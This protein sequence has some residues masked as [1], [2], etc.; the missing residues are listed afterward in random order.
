L[1]G[2][3]GF[4]EVWA[5]DTT[6]GRRVALKFLPCSNGRSTREE[7][8][9]L[10]VVRDLHHPNL[11]RIEQIWCT[12]G[13]IVVAME[14][15]DGSLRDLL[16]VCRRDMG[17]PVM[18]DLVCQ[19]LKQA[20]TALDF[21]NARQHLVHG[22]LSAIHHCDIKPSNILLVG[23]TVKLAD[24][25][26]AALKYSAGRRPFAAGTP[27]YAAPEI[28]EGRTS[29]RTDQFALAV[30]YCELRSGRL[31]YPH[32]PPGF[33]RDYIPPPPDLSML[34]PQESPIIARALSPIPTDRWPTCVEMIDRLARVVG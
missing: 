26:L 25:G 21:L 15:A 34:T 27:A 20:A 22:Q 14:L 33:P 9:A 13:H 2:S 11:I 32:P 17:T 18:P 30:T 23:D 16:D 4:A 31:P 6:D 29:D 10:Q 24:F 8:R 12:P 3:G 5:A 28:Y 1:I 7:I 19:F